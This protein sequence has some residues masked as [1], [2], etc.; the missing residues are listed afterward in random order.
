M[1]YQEDVMR[2]ARELGGYSL[3]EA[4]LL[5]R[6]MGKKIASEMAAHRD[7]FVKGAEAKG[8]AENVAEL[9]FEQAAKFAGYGFNKG[10]AAAY[11]QV[12][13]Q[14]AFLKANYPVEFLAASMTLDIGST[15]RLN[16]FR[17]ESSRLGIEVR[18]PDINGSQAFFACD[19]GIGGGVIY[20]ALAAV[21]NVGRQA[22]DHLVMVREEGGAFRSIADFAR[23]IDPRLVNKRAFES[24]VRAGAFDGLHKNR[25]QLIDSA[26][27]VLGDAARHIRD[28]DAGQSSLFVAAEPARETLPLL[29]TNDWP[30]HERL[31]EEFNAIGFYLSGHPLDSYAQ[32]LKRLGVQRYADL[33]ADTRRSAVKSTLAG[34]VIRRQERRGK[35]GDPFAFVGLSDPTGM[36]EVML[37]AEAL[38]EARTKLEPGASVIM[39]VVGDWNEDELKLRAISVEN[40]DVAA[41]N[42]GE[43]LRIFL[44]DPVPIPQIAAQLRQPGKGLI[45]LVVPVAGNAQEVEI[46]LPKR[47]A[48]SPQLKSMIKAMAGVAE[49]ETV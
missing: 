44:T 17:Q 21:K 43:G 49:V 37:F 15:D 4:D 25:K 16:V 20:Y 30:T 24:L 22:M 35:S 28:R 3:G 38:R 33:L 19:A 9:I 46:S 34:T 13:Y 41:A 6:A 29:A 8:V 42:A 40:L 1:T 26:D 32:A 27:I 47:V 31:A 2:I 11:A 12:A 5:R 39:R 14:T 10:H 7:K 18:A 23:R 36:F 48:V 45:T